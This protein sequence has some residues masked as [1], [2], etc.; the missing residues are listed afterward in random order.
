LNATWRKIYAIT[1]LFFGVLYIISSCTILG[2][3]IG[4]GLVLLSTFTNF[5]D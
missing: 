4:F 1:F 2:V 3:M 5:T